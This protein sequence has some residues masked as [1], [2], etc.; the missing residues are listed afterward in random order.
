MVMLHSFTNGKERLTV[1]TKKN[2]LAFTD[3]ELNA[4]IIRRKSLLPKPLPDRPTVGLGSLN[5]NALIDYVEDQLDFGVSN[6]EDF[7]RC[8]AE[9]LLETIYGDGFWKWWNLQ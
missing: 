4:E 6:H 5:W 9:E 7:Y 1:S 8:L 3:E 2:I